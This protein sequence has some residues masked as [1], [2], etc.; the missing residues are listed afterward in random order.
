MDRRLIRLIVA[1]GALVLL[2]SIP[3]G[4]QQRAVG[5]G[6]PDEVTSKINPNEQETGEVVISRLGEGQLVFP[7]DGPEGS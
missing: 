4:A 2:S 1:L 5:E 7:M 3:A 6:S